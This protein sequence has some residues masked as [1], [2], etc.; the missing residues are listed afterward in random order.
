MQAI[1]LNIYQQC[2]VDMQLAD[3]FTSNLSTGLL[4]RLCQ[5][6]PRNVVEMLRQAIG[7]ACIRAD[8]ARN[9]ELRV[10]DLE[11]IDACHD[12]EGV[13]NFH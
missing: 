10:S 13:S 9:A 11:G 4:S 7:N 3:Y 5:L 8:I 2:L 1:T 12:A 6:P